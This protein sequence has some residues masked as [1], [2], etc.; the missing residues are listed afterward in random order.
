MRAE[1]KNEAAFSA[2]NEPI[3]TTASSP[4]A[5]ARP[6]AMSALFVAVTRPF[7][8]CTSSRPTSTGSDAV[9]AGKK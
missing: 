2:K 7:A 5:I 4:A 9:N 1:T 6:A 8:R 3:E